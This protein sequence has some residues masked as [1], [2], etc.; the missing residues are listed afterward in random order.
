MP[1]LRQDVGRF[2]PTFLRMPW[3]LDK[4]Y[5][6]LFPVKQTRFLLVISD[7]RV[8]YEP[9][10]EF[11]GCC[12]IVLVAELM[13]RLCMQMSAKALTAMAACA[14]WLHPIRIKTSG[15][16]LTYTRGMLMRAYPAL[17]FSTGSIKAHGT[18]VEQ[19]VRYIAWVR[20]SLQ[21][22]RRSLPGAPRVA[23]ATGPPPPPAGATP[24]G[25][26]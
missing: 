3:A 8:F 25:H 5:I 13:P 4:V 23:T 18:S 24:R 1:K 17:P 14:E 21:S 12:R 22:S 20:F 2:Q 11:R 16:C 9:H 26:W 7:S 6:R 19:K 15:A 10:P